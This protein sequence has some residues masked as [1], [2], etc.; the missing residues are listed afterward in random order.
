MHIC[1]LSNEYPIW[2]TGGVGSFLQTFSRAVVQRGHKVTIIGIGEEEKTITIDDKGVQIVRLPKPKSPWLRFIENFSKLNKKIK[3]IHSLD[4]IDVVETPEMGLSFIKKIPGIKYVIRLHGGHHFFAESENRG[5]HWKKGWMEKKSFTKADAFIAVSDY[6]KNHTA[7]YLS[8]NQKQVTIIN[9]PIDSDLFSPRAHIKPE[10]YNIT[11]AGTICE[12]K[13]IRQLIEAVIQLHKKYPDLKL[14][15]Y[16]RDWKF[17]NGK[18][19]LEML[20]EKYTEGIKTSVIFHGIIPYRE[21]PEKYAQA[22]VCVFPSHMETQGLVAPEAMAMEKPVIFTKL[23]P[24]PETI[25]DFKTG[26]LCDPH[27]PEDIAEKLDWMLSNYEERS[28]MG[29][30]ARSFVLEKYNLQKILDKNIAFY[31]EIR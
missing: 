10:P 20:K 19:Y 13:G 7:K 11:F 4:P 5:I 28:G 31:K 25:E 27:L 30:E 2:A 8:Y 15:V 3:E 18:S 21:L 23:G 26:L 16:G 24:G 14:H 1:F 6:V 22:E 9:Y 17:A 12:K 29:K